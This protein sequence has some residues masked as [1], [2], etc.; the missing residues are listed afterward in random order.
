M[1]RHVMIDAR[2]LKM[3]M[4]NSIHEAVGA[5]G[6]FQGCVCECLQELSTYLWHLDS[7]HAMLQAKDFLWF[8]SKCNVFHFRAQRCP[9]HL[10]RKREA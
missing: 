3:L 6:S 8:L 5:V 4:N 1:Y 9:I 7:H 10:P 2:F